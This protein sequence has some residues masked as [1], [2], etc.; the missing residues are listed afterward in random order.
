MTKHTPIALK[1]SYKL[2]NHGPVSI[3]TSAYG[4]QRNI[5]AASWTMPVDFLPAKV[6]V[7]I[8]KNTYTRELVD[9]SGEFALQFPMRK[10]AK[11]TLDVGDASGR[12]ID[13]FSRFG[14]KTFPSLRIAAPLIED[15]IG[16]LEC[17]VIK[18]GA[19]SMDVI[20]GEAVAAYADAEQFIDGRWHFS[21]D[22]QKRSIHYMAGGEFYITGD[23][24]RTDS[25]YSGE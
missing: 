5:M 4:N 20:I 10:I 23:V 13:K 11:L 9:A 24:F 22:P 15:C 25:D 2:F 19:E 16:W 3:V 6:A 8:D 12:D 14:I 21:D 1:D 18:Q 17:R 7:V